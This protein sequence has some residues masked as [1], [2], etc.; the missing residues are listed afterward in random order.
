M[1]VAALDLLERGGALAVTTRGVAS[2]SGSSLAA[3]NELFGGKAGVVGALYAEG[4]RQLAEELGRVH[5]ADD[6]AQ[7]VLDLA[8]AVRT[9]ASRH[10]HLYEVMFSRP[11]AEFDP[12]LDDQRAAAV[13]YNI[14]VQRVTRLFVPTP[15]R[16]AAKDAAIGLFAL[17]QGL[18]SLEAA[19]LLGS[20]AESAERRWRAAVTAMLR[21]VAEA[22]TPV[23]TGGA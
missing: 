13:I 6:P 8:L 9:F 16:G 22:S 15:S 19:G 1:C 12:D 14:V 18:V 4:F 2:A 10:R 17:I 11:F 5:E 20:S 7:A 23:R 21:G 3:V